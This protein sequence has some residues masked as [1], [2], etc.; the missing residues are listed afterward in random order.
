MLFTEE[1]ADAGQA[2]TSAVNIAVP[3]RNLQ[4]IQREG[5]DKQDIWTQAS[6]NRGLRWQVIKQRSVNLKNE[7]SRP[8][9]NSMSS[10]MEDNWVPLGEEQSMRNKYGETQMT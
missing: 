2:K 8:V 10:A 3:L 9:L 1:E 6:R 7:S 4:S 5:W